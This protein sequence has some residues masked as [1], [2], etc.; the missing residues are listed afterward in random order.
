LETARKDAEQLINS[1]EFWQADDMRC[2]RRQIEQSG[3]LSGGRLD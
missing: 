1:E 2:L 3:V